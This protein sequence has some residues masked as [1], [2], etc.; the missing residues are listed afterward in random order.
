[1]IIYIIAIATAPLWIAAWR[2]IGYSFVFLCHDTKNI[3]AL[4]RWN[5]GIDTAGQP[6]Y[7][8]ALNKDYIAGAR[9][10]IWLS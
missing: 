9:A 10:T 2:A 4:I 6:C 7:E 8:V 1:M 3:P 5:M